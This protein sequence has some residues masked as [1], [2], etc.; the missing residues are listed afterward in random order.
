MT[1]T[2]EIFFKRG[3]TILDTISTSGNCIELCTDN[4]Y[5]Y[6][7]HNTSGLKAFSFDGTSLS[8]V[9][10]FDDNRDY[11]RVATNG[12]YVYTLSNAYESGLSAFKMSGDG[13][14]YLRDT[15]ICPS[16]NGYQYH[17]R[18]DISNNI[19]TSHDYWGL[20]YYTFDGESFTFV[21][22]FNGEED[23]GFYCK[24]TWSDGT[25]VY[26]YN[27]QSDS[28]FYIFSY[29]SNSLNKLIEYYID[30]IKSIVGSNFTSA[31]ISGT[32]LYMGGKEVYPIIFSSAT[33]DPGECVPWRYSEDIDEDYIQDYGHSCI[34]MDD[35]YVYSV[36]PDI[37]DNNQ[38]NILKMDKSG[39]AAYHLIKID[40]QEFDDEIGS[41]CSDGNYLYFSDDNEKLHACELN[42]DL[43]SI[44]SDGEYL[45][46]LNISNTNTTAYQNANMIINHPSGSNLQI[47]DI[48]YVYINDKLIFQGSIN[49]IS[50][51]LEK[52]QMDI[53]GV[54]YT[55]WEG[56]VTNIGG[57]IE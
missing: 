29:S 34:T 27:S 22:K 11:R 21:D 40:T 23:E 36:G 46:N 2:Y 4:T 54:T 35:N 56:F 13:V 26:A 50:K 5:V 17:I 47:N 53:I 45:T 55:M 52:T 7:V 18:C 42:K 41:L 3:F 9:N 37:G 32:I 16:A 20:K 28:E 6:G 51:Y 44:D 48:V 8:V 19:F 33:E 24:P 38:I 57:E 10:S 39:A 49:R 25:L 15:I 43:F 12:T 31:I 30:D 14:L 1:V